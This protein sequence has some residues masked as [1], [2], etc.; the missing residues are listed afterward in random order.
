MPG[1]ETTNAARRTFFA[2]VIRPYDLGYKLIRVGDFGDGGYLLPNDLEDIVACFSPGVSLQSSFE[3]DLAK[4]GIPSFM[5][6]GSVEEPVLKIPDSNFIKKHLAAKSGPDVIS[7]EDWISTYAPT[8]GDMILQMDIEGAEYPVL[9]TLPAELLNRFRIIVLE[10]HRIPSIL[11]KP[12]A[13][14]RAYPALS[15]LKDGFAC[16]HIHP[17]NASGTVDI[18]GETF[19][20]VIEATFVR[21]DRV[22]QCVPAT[23]FPH[24]LDR[25]HRPNGPLL[26]LPQEWI[27]SAA[28]TD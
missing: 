10:L 2:D 6:D 15:A 4:H 26:N 18:E 14:K 27:G 20:R 17:N 22:K 11:M 28:V 24:A 5:A 7:L 9:S 19:P 13:F 16:A 8:E 3:M 12:G 1:S 23:D 25:R 21:R